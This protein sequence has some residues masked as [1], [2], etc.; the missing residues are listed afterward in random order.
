MTTTRRTILSLAG[1]APLALAL[2][3]PAGADPGGAKVPGGLK[4]G[5]ELD[6]FVADLAAKDEFSGSLL[7]THRGRPV[8]SR[9][10]GMA[11]KARGIRNGP[12]TIFALA[13]VTKVITALSVVQ[14]VER[15]KLSFAAR[16]G[17]LL[18]GFAPEIAEAVTIHHL[19]THT[20]GLGDFHQVPG[21]WETARTWA[22][23][24]QV[25][26]GITQVIRGMPVAFPAGS[27]QAYSNAGFHLLGAIVAKVS[28][29]SYYDYV[30]R[31][32]FQPAGMSSSDF[33]T[34]PEWRT[35]P[36]IAHP[37]TGPKSG[38][39][40]DDIDSRYFIGTPAGE[41]FCT[42]ADLDRFTQ[43]L[44]RGKLIS[45]P[46]LQLYAGGKVPLPPMQPPPGSPPPPPGPPPVT[47]QCYGP[48][49]SVT[50]GQWSLSH[51]GGSS[52]ISTSLEVF[53]DSRWTVVV[54]SNYDPPAVQP[55]AGMARHLIAGQR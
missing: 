47:L 48:I 15:G 42:C 18:D 13:S 54:F 51:G 12:D 10:Y 34:K 44:L 37:Y 27:G 29:L 49:G 11:D 17:T 40:T 41:A 33:Y 5:G 43:A 36:R 24:Q 31:N 52:G 46:F 23:A 2:G 38:E 39:R 6:R 26:D 53:P 8:L 3:N 21:F 50:G 28:G 30:R 35:D 55:V 16:L 32:V 45:P 9:S 19:L 22:S 1:A 14:L 7:L 20:S 25:M 4:A